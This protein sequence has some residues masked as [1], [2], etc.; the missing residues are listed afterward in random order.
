M[1][2]VVWMLREIQ[3][4]LTYFWHLKVYNLMILI[5]YFSIVSKKSYEIK[6]NMDIREYNRKKVSC[7]LLALGRGRKMREVEEDGTEKEQKGWG[8]RHSKASESG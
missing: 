7:I 5:K 3:T 1:G 6:S 8:K 2:M 4:L